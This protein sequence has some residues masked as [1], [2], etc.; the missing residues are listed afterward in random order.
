MLSREMHRSILLCVLGA[1]A[2]EKSGPDL[3][4]PGEEDLSS[5]RRKGKK[6]KPTQ[7]VA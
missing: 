4:S 1:F 3:E 2:R 5:Q 6:G 7:T